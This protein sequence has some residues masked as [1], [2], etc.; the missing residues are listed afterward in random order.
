MFMILY[1]L[2]KHFTTFDG[3]RGIFFN[4]SSLSLGQ[5][6]QCGRLVEAIE[7]TQLQHTTHSTLQRTYN[8]TTQDAP[9]TTKQQ[10]PSRLVEAIENTQLQHTTHNTWLLY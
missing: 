4:F 1:I 10:Q 3:I 7:N 6:V 2:P 8:N 5:P 9:H